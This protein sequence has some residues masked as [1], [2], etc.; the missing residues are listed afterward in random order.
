MVPFND[1]D[2]ANMK[3]KGE[4][5]ELSVIGFTKSSNVK[6]HHFTNKDA[7]CIL[8]RENDEV[9]KC[10]LSPAFLYGEYQMII[11]STIL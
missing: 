9:T 7:M 5:R 4:G 1:D 2:M 11:V 8:P 3:Y 6:S 10:I